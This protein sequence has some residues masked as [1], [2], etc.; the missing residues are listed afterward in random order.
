MG[1]NGTLAEKRIPVRRFA[2]TGQFVPFHQAAS[3]PPFWNGL[4]FGLRFFAS[5][6]GVPSFANIGVS[7]LILM[8]F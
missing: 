4:L 6:L 2:Q 8:R 1:P 3:L 5:I 7:P